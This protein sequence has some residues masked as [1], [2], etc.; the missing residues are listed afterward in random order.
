MMINPYDRDEI[1]RER[2]NELMQTARLA[3]VRKQ[4]KRAAIAQQETGQDHDPDASIVGLQDEQD[5]RLLEA[6]EAP[7]FMNTASWIKRAPVQ[8]FLVGMI[9][10]IIVGLLLVL[11]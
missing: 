9:S 5:W 1:I 6:S 3:R 8:G 7:L 2:H 10:L 4:A 11:H